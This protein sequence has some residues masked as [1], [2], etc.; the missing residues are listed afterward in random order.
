MKREMPKIT[1]K[2]SFNTYKS[3]NQH[4]VNNPSGTDHSRT[5]LRLKQRLYS[6]EASQ[7]VDP[8][9]VQATEGG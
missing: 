6:G 4:Q 8:S 7:A 2:A 3:L 5:D 1:G 9:T